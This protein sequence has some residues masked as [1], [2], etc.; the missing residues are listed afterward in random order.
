MLVRLIDFLKVGNITAVLTNLTSAGNLLEG[1]T[2]GVSSIIDTWLL[3][4]SIELSGERNRTMYILKSRGMA[5]SNQVREFV[6]S[7]KGIQVRDV[8]V[9]P[10]GVLTGSAR[11]AQESRERADALVRRQSIE[12]R[13]RELQQ[14]Q[15]AVE[16]QIA[17]LRRDFEQYEAEMQLL[18]L[19]EQ[20]S[21]GSLERDR[22]EMAS[23]RRS[24]NPN[25]PILSEREEASNE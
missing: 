9:G 1:T 12:R 15:K 2:V 25:R 17:A 18:I 5:H 13:Q 8:Y 14:K 11:M 6:L 16:A 4:R 23:S 10:E 21:E 7:E 24:D 3:L 20:G 22:Q 19:Q